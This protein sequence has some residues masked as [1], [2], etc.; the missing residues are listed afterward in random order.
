MK[1]ILIILSILVVFYVAC[2]LKYMVIDGYRP[3]ESFWA[4][5]YLVKNPYRMYK[6]I[7]EDAEFKKIEEE[8]KKKFFDGIKNNNEIYLGLFAGNIIRENMHYPN[9]ISVEQ[10][11]EIL[12]EAEKQSIITPL[13]YYSLYSTKYLSNEENIKNPL[14]DLGKAWSVIEQAAYAGNQNAQNLLSHYYEYGEVFGYKTTPDLIEGLAWKVNVLFQDQSDVTINYIDL[15]KKIFIEGEI[16]RLQITDMDSLQK[17]IKEIS[18]NYP[19]NQFIAKKSIKNEKV[20][21]HQRKLIKETFENDKEAMIVY[22]EYLYTGSF[23]FKDYDGAYYLYQKMLNKKDAESYLNLSMFYQTVGDEF[24]GFNPYYNPALALQY[25]EEAGM[26]GSNGASLFLG[27]LYTRGD[28]THLRVEP[29]KAIGVGWYIINLLRRDGDLGFGGTFENQLAK[30]T[31][32]DEKRKAMK[33]VNEYRTLHNI[34][35]KYDLN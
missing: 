16:A 20:V 25:L 1:K 33:L 26:L 28:S 12:K 17:R 19:I 31:T 2:I 30:L 22:A 7:G 29:D 13:Y 24:R 5:N 32:D 21:E 6:K 34:P 10:M 23:E 9:E 11:L 15:N 14:Y 3:Y 4:T 8:R 35:N 27:G 18:T